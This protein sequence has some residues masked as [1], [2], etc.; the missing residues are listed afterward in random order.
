MRAK[1]RGAWPP[2]TAWRQGR[3]P[4]SRDGA[5]CRACHPGAQP[6]L[7]RAPQSTMRASSREGRF[8][9]EM[10]NWALRWLRW[11]RSQ[12]R[13]C[14][15]PA[16]VILRKTDR[17]TAV[18]KRRLGACITAGRSAPPRPGR[19]RAGRASRASRA[20]RAARGA[21][22]RNNRAT[23]FFSPRWRSLWAARAVR[24]AP[25]R[26]IFAAPRRYAR[27]ASDDGRR[28]TAFRGLDAN[29]C[30]GN[31]RPDPETGRHAATRINKTKMR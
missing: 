26:T 15:R 31:Y 23:S 28:P 20:P 12:S 2:G 24:T 7:L 9:S 5:A 17:R 27:A 11:L 29:G 8:V 21:R 14:F 25:R 10:V 30:S 3:G 1:A 22:A 16:G 19:G 6:A 18:I 13:R 4:S